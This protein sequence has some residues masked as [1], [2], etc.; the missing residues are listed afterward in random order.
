M[1]E[2]SSCAAAA[3]VDKCSLLICLMYGQKVGER[4]QVLFNLDIFDY[5]LEMPVRILV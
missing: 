1:I 3:E 4:V 2:E 5:L